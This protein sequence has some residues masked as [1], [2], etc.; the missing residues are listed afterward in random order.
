ME[1]NKWNQNEIAGETDKP[2]PKIRPV[3]RNQGILRPTH[4]DQL[5]DEQHPARGIW[6]FVSE[7]DLQRFY[8]A[9]VSVEGEAGRSAFD[10]RMLVSVWVYA[11]SRGIGSAREISRLCETDPPFQW[12]TGFQSING[13][14]LSDFRVRHKEGLDE[15][16]A[17]VL[18]L[19]SGVGLIKLE[20]V[21]Q[22]GTK[23]RA[24]ASPRSFRKKERIKKHLEAAREHVAAMGDPNQEPKASTKSKARKQ[25]AARERAK[26]IERAL[27]EAE[28]L[29]GTKGKPSKKSTAKV[30]TTD[31]DA[32][33]MKQPDGGVLPSYN[34]QLSV[35][36]EA[37]FIADVDVTNEANDSQQL[38]P[39]MERIVHTFESRPSQ[40][41]ADGDYT[42]HRS[43]EAMAELEIDYYS[44]W[45]QTPKEPSFQWRG[46]SEAF[47]PEQFRFD[48]ERD[49]YVCPAGRTLV[50]R[51]TINH[52]NGRKSRLY[53]AAGNECAA[54]PY[55]H[56]C[57]SKSLARGQG[58]VVSRSVVLKSVTHFQEKMQTEEAQQIYRRRNEVA[59]FPNLWIKSKFRLTMFYVRGL[60]KVAM[61]AKWA[62]LAYNIHHWLRLR[63]STAPLEE[64]TT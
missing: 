50:Y 33:M 51:T 44:T 5:I 46:L 25:A 21:T 54:C 60:A 12:L 41:M 48:S 58:R 19:L 55:H 2:S 16:F 40:V 13:H 63:P 30:S 36:G 61:V 14:T 31:P 22:D 62:A 64:A 9:I 27:K 17:Q 29:Q 57:C 23:I 53:R 1:R 52:P 3:D 47:Y 32:R 15:L 56:Q 4:I 39:A 45:K 38:L 59:E 35:D 8:D 28:K 24:N 49:I 42:N 10:P 18:G 20:R 43:V 34:V 7:L 26:R 37:K 6:D 11:Y